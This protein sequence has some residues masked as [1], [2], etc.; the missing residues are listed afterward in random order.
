MKIT[1]ETGP[2]RMTVKVQDGRDVNEKDIWYILYSISKPFKFADETAQ[3]YIVRL[4]AFLTYALKG[5]GYHAYTIS[6]LD[7]EYRI[8]VSCTISQSFDMKD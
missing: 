6:R 1:C 8:D 7:I 3:K 2:L 5:N 4:G